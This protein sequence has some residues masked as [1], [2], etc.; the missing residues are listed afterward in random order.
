LERA[1]GSRT[2]EVYVLN[3]GATDTEIYQADLNRRSRPR[4]DIGGNRQPGRA[5]SLPKIG[6]D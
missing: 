6:H 4:A 3:P 5:P 2:Q 1:C